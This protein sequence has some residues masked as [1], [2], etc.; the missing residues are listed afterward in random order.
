MGSKQTPGICDPCSCTGLYAHI[1]TFMA[2]S[3][4]ELMKRGV[5]DPVPTREYPFAMIYCRAWHVGALSYKLHNIRYPA[6]P[7]LLLAAKISLS[8]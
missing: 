8:Q 2:T 5:K 3:E 1:P 6:F 4:L 7:A